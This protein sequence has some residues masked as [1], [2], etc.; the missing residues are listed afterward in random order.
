MIMTMAR[1]K[2]RGE[3]SLVHSIDDFD[4]PQDFDDHDVFDS[5]DDSVAYGIN[6]LM[7][8]EKYKHDI[9]QNLSKGHAPPPGKNINI[10]FIQIYPR[11]THFPLK[12]IQIYPRVTHL[13]L[14]N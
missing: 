1:G 4:D 8:Q 12:F 9:Y 14:G 2:A 10:E 11:V 6:A 13:P 3:S 7:V 5:N